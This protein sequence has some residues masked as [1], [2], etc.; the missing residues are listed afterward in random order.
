MLVS[1]G[2]FQAQTG[3]VVSTNLT[4]AE[5]VLQIE[6][7]LSIIMADSDGA[8]QGHSTR[9]ANLEQDVNDAKKL[10]Q[11]EAHRLLDLEKSLND[12]LGEIEG[13][14]SRLADL[15]QA[16]TD[17]KS[18]IQSVTEELLE[19]ESIQNDTVTGLQSQNMRITKLEQKKH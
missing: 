15:E 14:T 19:I 1:I 16:S 4:L 2:K 12:T 3:T 8:Y 18:L 6:E 13:H 10:S 11:T 17:S 9:I 7:K 5:H